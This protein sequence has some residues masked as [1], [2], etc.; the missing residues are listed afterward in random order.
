MTP[1]V[2]RDPLSARDARSGAD[3]DRAQSRPVTGSS[4]YIARV[5]RV[6]DHIDG[7][8][9]DELDL[10]ALAR[11]ARLSPWHFHRVF[12]ALTGETVAD[13][14]RRRRLEV[15]AA[16]LLASDDKA[17]R[18]ALDVGFG[19]AEVFTR[20]FRAYFG[21][22]PTAWRRGGFRAW[23]SRHRV[24]LSKIRQADRKTYQ[25]VVQAFL[26]DGE[27]WPAGHV[28]RRRKGDVME[29]KLQTIPKTRVAYLRHVGPYGGSGIAQ[30]WQRFAAWCEEHGLMS[31]RRRM[32]GVCQDIPDLTPPE[33]CRYDAC[34]EV[35][36]SFRPEGEFGVQ[37]LPGG[38]HA[39]T[40]F[41]GTPDRIH[42]A[43]MALYAGW[44]PDSG[45]QA[46]D[47]PCV[48]RYIRDP[49]LDRRDGAFSCWL[50][51]P[52]RVV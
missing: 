18:I 47:R 23:A 2:A 11:V 16:R 3:H 35:D 37:T 29:V 49:S 4:A 46:D 8:L 45:Y 9:P 52:V 34:V 7:H 43:W 31:P 44:L 28:P 41:T 33:K 17:L 19:S 30:A 25:E 5:N 24:A 10:R 20:C 48:E 51:L 42:A 6:L 50:C 22:T 38:L 21:V 1:T 13:R 36:A 26:Q 40:K 12:Q 32:Y 39:C 15:A 14:V 27:L